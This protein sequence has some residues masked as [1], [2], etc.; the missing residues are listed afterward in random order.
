[1]AAVALT[2]L[3]SGCSSSEEDA[4]DNGQKAFDRVLAKVKGLEGAERAKKLAA[5]AKAEG[6]E[7][8]FYTSL[9]SETEEAVADEFEEA[10]DVEVSVYRASGETV[11]QRVSEEADAGFRGADVVETGGPEMAGLAKEGLFMRYR[12]DGAD[13]LVEGSLHREWTA[14]RFNTFVVAWNTKAVSKDEVPRSY[15]ELAEPRWKGKLVI[16]EQDADWYK[17]MLEYL[18]AEG[19]SEAEADEVLRGIAANAQVATSHSLMTQLLSAGEFALAPD[20][21]QYQVKDAQEDGAPVENE[22]FVEPVFS[23]PQGMALMNTAKHPAAAVLFA[24]WLVGPGQKV[25]VESN[26]EVSRKDL[27]FTQSAKRRPIDVEE[28]EAQTEEWDDRYAK[29]I[30]GVPKAPEPE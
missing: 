30:S 27:N 12:P 17:A 6:G 22:P 3:L 4:S 1:L 8:T 11:A 24:D 21:Y 15:E 18:M 13:E 9:V 5:L 2:V 28:F 23:R 19:K 25:L 29:L 26:Q 16:E 10:Y 20:Q 14:V 7:L